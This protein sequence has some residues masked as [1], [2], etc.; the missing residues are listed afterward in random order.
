L[1][2]TTNGTTRILNRWTGD[3]TSND[4]PRAIVGDPNNNLRVST[5]YIED[6]SFIRLKNLTFGYTLPRNI[7]NKITASQI[8]VYVTGQ[9]L[10]TLTHYTGFDPEVSVSGIDQGVY[11]QVRTLI[12]G[13]NIGF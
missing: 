8:R 6:G 12:G 10:L 9:N 7:L 2:S 5:H 1:Y 3:G 4:V 11:P 13:I